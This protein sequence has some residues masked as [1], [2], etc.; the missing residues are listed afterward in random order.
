MN[1]LKSIFFLGAVSMLLIVGCS[2]DDELAQPVIGTMT[3]NISGLE[4]LGSNYAYE[5]WIIV[6]G[7][8]IT[9]GIFNV[10]SNG[11]LTQNKFELNAEDLE[12]ATAYALTI[13]PSPDNDS[14]PSKVHILGGNFSGTSADLTV[15]HE[16]AIGHNFND[17]LGGYL[18]ATPTDGSLSTDEKSGI[19]WEDP[20]VNPAA[21]SLFL[22][23]LPEGW[24]YEGWVV[25][26]GRPLS[27]GKF[28]KGD[29][30]DFAA[31]FSGAQP[32]PP[33]PGEDFLE[34]APTGISFPLDLSGAITVI[35]IE[36]SPDN[37]DAPF[38]LKPLIHNIPNPVT[39]LTF[40]QMQN[41]A[42]ATNPLGTVT[43]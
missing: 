25:V 9:A 19:W 15:E 38:L 37:S 7:Q 12:K 31:P 30:Q 21:Q 14:S 1:N 33:F 3:L 26:D 5:N 13:E 40:Y 29:E 23:T 2:D 32:G 34:N 11:N 35:S 22:P 27:T 43:R 16:L 39:P 18:L 20:T 42:N 28:L 17:A 36:P 6:D 24:E 10:D 4:D 41:N 8:P